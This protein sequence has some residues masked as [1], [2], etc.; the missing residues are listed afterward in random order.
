MTQ[1]MPLGKS[2]MKYPKLADKNDLRRKLMDEDIACLKTSYTKD[3]PFKG[4][5]YRQWAMAQASELRVSEATIYYHTN[6]DYQAKMKTKN[7]RAHSKAH[8][9]EDYEAHRA[10][11]I[12]LRMRRW[13]RNPDLREW[14]YNVS[15]KNE[16][17]AKRKTVMGKPL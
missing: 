2:N 12:Q 8:D 1:W 3:Y 7:A 11:E 6:P 13:D 16:K 14:H 15:A 5:S 10:A 17:R 9:L 4:S